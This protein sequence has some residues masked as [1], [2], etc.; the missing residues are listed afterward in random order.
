MHLSYRTA[1]DQQPGVYHP[2]LTSQSSSA[3]FPPS[4]A[5][6]V[7]TLVPSIG[8][9]SW[10]ALLPGVSLAPCAEVSWWWKVHFSVFKKVH[11]GFWRLLL[12]QFLFLF[13]D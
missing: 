11:D 13:L 2:L 12:S 9:S 10:D 8:M 3:L 5:S 7:P 1:P 6:L 4:S